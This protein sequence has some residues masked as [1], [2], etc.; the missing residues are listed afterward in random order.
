MSSKSPQ[1]GHPL[2]PS[3]LERLRVQRTWHLG[4]DGTSWSDNLWFPKAQSCHAL[5]HPIARFT[6]TRTRR[7]TKEVLTHTCSRPSSQEVNRTMF[8]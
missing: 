8:Q 7:W 6:P 4:M 5:S 1:P 2:A 3:H